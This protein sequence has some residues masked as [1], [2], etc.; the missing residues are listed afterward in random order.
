MSKARIEQCKDGVRIHDLRCC[1][2]CIHVKKTWMIHKKVSELII[3]GEE[4]NGLV[5]RRQAEARLLKVQL[6]YCFDF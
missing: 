5:D 6:L 1:L 2:L 3:C 4:G